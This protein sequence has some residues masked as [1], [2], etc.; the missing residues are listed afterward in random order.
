VA[1]LKKLAE[2][3]WDA[4]YRHDLDAC[5]ATYA[6]DAELVLPLAAPIKGKEAIRAT[7][8]MYQ[9]AFP[10]EKP[11][12]IRHI[13]EGD[14]VVTEWASVS[15]HTGPMMMPNGQSLPPTGRK[16]T[17]S[18]VTVQDIENGKIKKQVF[19]FD[20]AALLQQLGL[21]PEMSAAN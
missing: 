12:S 19:Y 14:T 2:E 1:D 21:M 11:T 15:T 10:D 3:G 8:E 13:S 20:V 9:T 4:Y 18:G 16:I 7:W 6:E 5:L 17:T